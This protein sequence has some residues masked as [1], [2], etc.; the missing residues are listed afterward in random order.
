MFLVSKAE[1]EAPSLAINLVRDKSLWAECV[2]QKSCS[3]FQIR[4][5][6]AASLSV[7]AVQYESLRAEC[8]AASL[9]TTLRGATLETHN[10]WKGY[11]IVSHP[12][13][14]N[15]RCGTSEK[16]TC[17]SRPDNRTCKLARIA[18]MHFSPRRK[19]SVCTSVGKTSTV[20]DYSL[21]TWLSPEFHCMNSITH[22]WTTATH[23]SRTWINVGFCFNYTMFFNYTMLS[24]LN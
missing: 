12:N 2:P 8:E 24:Q 1:C 4:E 21:P 7:K 11:N 20:V 3:L 14:D 13:S 22:P 18:D 19:F 16:Y 15:R 6:E 5:C 23:D 17:H 10:V 9:V